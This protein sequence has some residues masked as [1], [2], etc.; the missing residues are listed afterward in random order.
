MQPSLC[1]PA[2]AAQLMQPSLCSPA[3]AAQLVQPRGL[4]IVITRKMRAIAVKDLCSCSHLASN[5][6]RGASSPVYKYAAQL[7]QPRDA[8][9]G[10]QRLN[11]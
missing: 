8:S 3:Y 7:V 2:Y 6:Y 1:S 11:Q 5:D 9:D 4:P 10:G